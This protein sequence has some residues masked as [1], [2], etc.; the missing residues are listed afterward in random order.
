MGQAPTR[1]VFFGNCV[2]SVLFL[3]VQHVSKKKTARWDECKLT[4]TNYNIILM[5]WLEKMQS[6]W[7]EAVLILW[8]RYS[9]DTSL[10][11]Y[12]SKHKTFVYHLY[13]AGPTYS[14]LV[15]HCI[16][17]IQFF[18][19]TG[20]WRPLLPAQVCDKLCIWIAHLTHQTRDIEPMLGQCNVLARLHTIQYIC[21]VIIK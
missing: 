17:V 10:V 21:P 18:C 14:T 2:F 6:L 13:N 19:V 5:S 20:T 1:I 15:Q 3:V 4:K 9:D 16:H 8:Y 12:P 7:L 11:L